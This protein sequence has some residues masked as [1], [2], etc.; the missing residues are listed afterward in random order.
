MLYTIET[1]Y[2]LGP[3]SLRGQQGVRITVRLFLSEISELDEKQGKLFHGPPLKNSLVDIV[4]RVRPGFRSHR[5]VNHVSLFHIYHETRTTKVRVFGSDRNILSYSR[6]F[7]EKPNRLLT[8][9][10]PQL[11]FVGL[12]VY[13]FT[14]TMEKSLISLSEN[15]NIR[16]GSNPWWP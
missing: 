11:S 4:S 12:C 9:L 1:S 7:G 6:T 14:G 8:T 16:Y 3:S 10:V 15:S 13:S 2:C 5:Y